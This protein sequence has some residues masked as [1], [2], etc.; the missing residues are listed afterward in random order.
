M[1]CRRR[2]RQS[3]FRE[4]IAWQLRAARVLTDLLERGT[5]EGLPVLE[6]TMSH[7]GTQSQAGATPGRALPAGPRSPRGPRRSASGWARN[8]TRTAG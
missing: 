4:Q 5:R 8:I 1:T 2:A 6:W 7:T 3:G